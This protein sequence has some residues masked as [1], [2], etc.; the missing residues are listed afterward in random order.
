MGLSNS[1]DGGKHGKASSTFMMGSGG[2]SNSGQSF[3]G[4]HGAVEI[5]ERDHTSRMDKN[6][7]TV[8]SNIVIGEG[9]EFI[10]DIRAMDQDSKLVNEINK[11]RD[12]IEPP[13]SSECCIY[14]EPNVVHH[15]RL[16]GTE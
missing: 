5:R 2:R 11:M 12:E 10:F 3:Y 1:V 14:R 4:D 8:V 15:I 7:T 6:A 13:S 16:K 9:K